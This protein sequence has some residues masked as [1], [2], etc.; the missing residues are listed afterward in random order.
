MRPRDPYRCLGTLSESDT[1]VLLELGADDYVSKPFSGRQLPARIRAAVRR[2]V[3]TC[4]RDSFAFGDVNV[5]FRTMELR[6]EGQCGSPHA[7]G[8]QN[9]E[10]YGP[11]CAARYFAA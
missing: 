3:R 11:E 7:P 2:S 4:A 5:K 6:R 1:I 8:I 9:T 10:V